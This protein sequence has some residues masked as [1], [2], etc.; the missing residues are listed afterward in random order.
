MQ[1]N[2]SGNGKQKTERGIFEGFT[3]PPRV[4]SLPYKG[5]PRGPTFLKVIMS[6]EYHVSTIS[7]KHLNALSPVFAAVL[8]GLND[9][10]LLEEVCHWG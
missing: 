6:Q 4:H 1:R 2:S 10:A 3:I 7:L 8:R 9:M 5:L